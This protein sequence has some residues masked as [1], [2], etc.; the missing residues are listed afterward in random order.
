MKERVKDYAKR[1]IKSAASRAEH[2]AGLKNLLLLLAIIFA[3]FALLHF[4][5]K[6][7][8]P[9]IKEVA[10]QKLQ[11]APT[12]APK[13]ITVSKKTEH[14]KNIKQTQTEAA[15]TYQPKFDFYK[16]LAKMTVTIPVDEAATTAISAKPSEKK[17]APIYVLQI[18]SLQKNSDAAQIQNVLKAAGY[19]T[20]IQPY[21]APDHT[22]WYRVLVGP[23]HDLKTAQAQ[24]EKLD[25][26]QTEALL[27]SM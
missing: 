24:Q 27:T 13:K 8:A 25:A 18:A 16:L 15:S 3:S 7:I 1:P 10:L 19:P 4:M 6:H 17:S 23:F 9:K 14:K 2:H 22:A 26:N 12:Q 5:Q 21:Q 20:F 11:T